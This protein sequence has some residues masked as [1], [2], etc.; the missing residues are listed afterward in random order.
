M[1]EQG[2]TLLSSWASSGH[3]SIRVAW[4]DPSHA[5][6]SYLGLGSCHVC[7]DRFL[8]FC[9]HLRDDSPFRCRSPFCSR[10]RRHSNLAAYHIS[11]SHGP[12][13]PAGF[14]KPTDF[15]PWNAERP[16]CA[17]IPNTAYRQPVE[18]T[19]YRDFRACRP[20]HI[21]RFDVSNVTQDKL[22]HL[23]H[24]SHLCQS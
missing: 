23:S 24:L 14:H 18:S 15:S 1:R 2:E 4:K 11:F 5:S 9:R 10:V 22:S 13:Q 16:S 7:R 19:T 12:R 6:F 20:C 3:L 8:R 17:A 21:R